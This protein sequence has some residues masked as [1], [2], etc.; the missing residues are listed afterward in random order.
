MSGEG[1]Q[2]REQLG[3]LPS[4]AHL[5]SVGE[6]RVRVLGRQQILHLT[7]S[8]SPTRK[9][10]AGE[11]SMASNFRRLNGYP[12]SSWCRSTRMRSTARRRNT[13]TVEVTNVSKHGFWLWLAEREHFLSFDHFPWF[14]EVSIR[15]LC[16]V[17]LPS[18]HHL[19]WPDLDVDLAV[20]SIDSPERFPL[21]SRRKPIRRLQPTAPS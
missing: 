13:S 21:I 9:E 15:Q 20:E 7:L 19:Y 3:S 12:H 8:P 10:R 4:P 18:P 14:R 5:L 2:Q 17:E 6:G 16:N 11:G 1:N